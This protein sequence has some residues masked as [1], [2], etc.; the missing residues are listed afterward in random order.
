MEEFKPT[1]KEQGERMLASMYAQMSSAHRCL[2]IMHQ[3][4]NVGDDEGAQQ[5]CEKANTYFDNAEELGKLVFDADVH[6]ARFTVD[7]GELADMIVQAWYDNFTDEDRLLALKELA[8]SASMMLQ[9]GI[10]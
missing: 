6:V 2:A 7:G 1:T 10:G 9:H 4:A 5:M 3:R 8:D